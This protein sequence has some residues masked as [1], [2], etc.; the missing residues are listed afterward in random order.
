MKLAFD[1]SILVEID[2][3][4]EKVVSLLKK[5]TEK[6]E[7]L[8]ISTITVSEILAGS[9]LQNKTDEAVMNAKEVLGQFDWKEMDGE[10]AETTAKLFAYLRLEKRGDIE[11]QDIVIAAT[12]ISEN[13]DALI[14][15]NKKDFLVFPNL[16][17][18]VYAPDEFSLK[19]MR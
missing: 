11:F 15:L 1:T 4:N 3:G 13:C 12:C 16:K 6:G 7:E 2:R 9:Y 8:V 5:L 19:F 17:S 18:K 10:V 14:T